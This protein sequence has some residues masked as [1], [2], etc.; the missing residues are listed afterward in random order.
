V[1]VGFYGKL[2]SHGDFLRRRVS[3]AFVERW[4]AWLQA[5][6][7]ASRSALGERWLDVFLTSPA[8][9]FVCAAG[10]CGPEPLI[11]LM[12]PSVDRVGRY[13]PFTLVSAL[14]ADVSL[15]TAA[16]GTAAF[17]DHAER[18]IVETLAAELVDFEGFDASVAK[19]RDELGAI[20]RSPQVLLD[21]AAGG[22][23]AADSAGCWQV[24]IGSSALLTPVFE[25]LLSLGLSSH[26]DPPVV[27]WTEGSARVEPCC[28]ITRGL[29]DPER[30]AALLEGSWATGGWQTAS[31]RLDPAL[32]QLPI[33]PLPLGFRSAA[34]TDV[35]KV[36]QINQDAFLE[37]PEIGLW[38]V[39]D[40]LGGHRDGEIASRMVCDALSDIEP[41][42]S[43][44]DMVDAAR[45]R[46]EQVNE[47]LFRNSARAALA[48]RSGS[49]VVVLL[50]RGDGG[51]ILWAGDSR[52]YRCRTGRLEQLTRDH[53]VA[54]LDILSGLQESHG[55]TRAVGVQPTLTLD[56]Q[57]ED[58]RAGDRLLLCSDGLTHTLPDIQIE[59]WMNN[60]DIRAAVDGLIAATLEAGGP[61]NVTVL[62]VEAQA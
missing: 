12:V 53:S 31:A 60:P 58:I 55:V 56:L 2:P 48:D 54:A 5:S 42:Q 6:V 19:L 8:W 41:N 9:R 50:A 23:L 27:W 51:A 52:A 61:D 49:T 30:F 4:D 16:T 36:R 43:F 39:A 29:P 62:I 11:G 15:I 45:H 44:G 3:D 13:F 38:V 7:A 28:L 47:A 40:G 32:E 14:P 57:R 34:A 25:Q 18:L 37:R 22:I 10:T 20:G 1:E 17:F 46:I 33:D 26:Y 35:G 59:T 21:G 24:P